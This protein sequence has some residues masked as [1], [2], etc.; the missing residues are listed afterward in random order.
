MKRYYAAMVLGLGVM[1]AG[2]VSGEDIRYPTDMGIVNLAQPPY[3]A[4]PTGKADATAAIQK[5]LDD[6]HLGDNWTLYLPN[7]TYLLSG[8]LDWGKGARMGPVLQG[9]SRDG[10]ILRLKDQ[11]PGFGNPGAPKA[12][13]HIVQKGSADAFCMAVRNLTIDT[14]SGNPGASGLQ[15]M[16]NNQ[17]AVRDVT[18][19]SGDGRGVIGLDMAFTDMIGPCLIKNVE[20]RGFDTGIATGWEVCSMTFEHIRLSGQRKFGFLNA[21]QCVSIRGLVSDNEVPAVVNKGGSSFLVLVDSVLTGTKAAANE[22]AIVNDAHCFLRNVRTPGY[23]QALESSVGTFASGGNPDEIEEFVSLAPIHLFPTLKHSLG[24]PVRETPEVAWGDPKDWANVQDFGA[25]TRDDL[26]DTEA[27]QKAIDSGAKTVYFPHPL[28]AGK[29]QTN[30]PRGSYRINGTVRIRGNVERLIGGGGSWGMLSVGGAARDGVFILEEGTAPVVI[31]EDFNIVDGGAA[32]V[33]RHRSGRTLVMRHVNSIMH[34]SLYHGDDGA[35][36]AFFED[37]ASHFPIGGKDRSGGAPNFH[38]GKGQ[39]IW[40]RQFNPEKNITKILN[41]GADFWVLG[42]K[43]E[44]LATLLENRPGAR[45]EILGGL[46]YPS[47]PGE[48]PQAAFRVLG[49]QFTAA[50]GEAGFHRRFDTL[51][52]ETHAGETK[53]LKRGEVP[54]RSGGSLLPLYCANR[55]TGDIAKPPTVREVKAA[56]DGPRAVELSWRGEG[57]AD[58]LGE[59]VVYR[60]GQ[61]LGRTRTTRMRDVG[62]TDATRYVYAVEVLDQAAAPRG[63]IE[64]AVTTPADQTPPKLTEAVYQGFPSRVELGFD[65]PVNLEAPAAPVFALD[66]ASPVL[67]VEPTEDA[68]RVRL[69]LDPAAPPPLR[70]T[71]RGVVDRARKPNAM[72]ASTLEVAV[73]VQP[74]PILRLDLAGSAV[75]A[76]VWDDSAWNQGAKAALS[77]TAE[78]KA[79]RIGI[80][81]YAQVVLGPVPVEGARAYRMRVVLRSAQ[82]EIPVSLQVRKKDQPYTIHGGRAV[83]ATPKPLPVEFD[84]TPT[85]SDPTASLYLVTSGEGELLIESAQVLA[86]P[87]E[88]ELAAP[89]DT[90]PPT[91]LSA[92][93]FELPARLEVV[94]SEPVAAADAQVRERYR[95]TPDTAVGALALSDD[96]RRVTLHL[97]GTVVPPSALTITDIADRAP[98]P[99]RLDKVLVEVRKAP[100]PVNLL[101][102][103]F[104]SGPEGAIPAGIMDNSAWNQGAK[105]QLALVK[106]P[107]GRALG[108]G[109]DRYAQI[110]LGRISVKKGRRYGVSCRLASTE[111]APQ[112]VVL[113]IRQWGAPYKTWGSGRFVPTPAGESYVFL[114]VA[115]GDDPSAAL[116]LETQGKWSLQI[117]DLR[118]IEQPDAL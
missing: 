100:T 92:T 64:A 77:M 39:K 28:P 73:P 101:Q 53:V 103:D 49:G 118:V 84:F 90:T 78:Q 33:F 52:E 74:R 67:A 115:E 72:A 112:P 30:L 16:A 11:A 87:T 97:D 86:L 7:G 76:G 27:I 21:G 85:A 45:T 80:A 89:V 83:K 1:V 8:T 42:L 81:R 75:P 35:G 62:L 117:D 51:V 41:D 93:A 34:N 40:A 69:L 44:V 61:E 104:E 111:G 31:I 54:G 116:Y 25:D 106:G 65:K 32:P 91:V 46:N 88:E 20:V 58:G 3:N 12:I 63:R 14:G 109:V 68:R 37:V 19:R 94:F 4:D 18:I 95:F 55:A 36:P 71:A 60:D 98:R 57:G 105:A 99:N 108:I 29:E 10:T 56:A 2:R 79:L 26:D 24:L 114:F 13:I 9:Q 96:G 59:Y 82:G 102:Q 22:A 43:T 107:D 15:F 50:I 66:P 113:Q 23:G 47:L 17:G 5:A 70:L 38:F 110:V 48:G 6:H